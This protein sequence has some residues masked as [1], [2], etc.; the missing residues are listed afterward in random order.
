M[1]N[2]FSVSVLCYEHEISHRL[3]HQLSEKHS[4]IFVQSYVQFGL[5]FLRQGA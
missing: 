2:Q 5:V 1:C 4:K 3:Q